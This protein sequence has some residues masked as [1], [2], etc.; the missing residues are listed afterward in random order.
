MGVSARIAAPDNNGT[1]CSTNA[2]NVRSLLLLAVIGE[3]VLSLGGLLYAGLTGNYR[4]V[5]GGLVRLAAMIALGFLAARRQSRWALW[6]FVTL[7]YLTA[8]T[9]LGLGFRAGEVEPNV[10]VIFA[11]FFSLGTAAWLGRRELKVQLV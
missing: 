5:P 4:A 1:R 2:S 11:V 3:A 8:F 6:T 10:L 7:E 9:A